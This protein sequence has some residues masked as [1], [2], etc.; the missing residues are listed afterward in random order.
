MKKKMTLRD[1]AAEAN[2]SLTAASLYLNGKARQYRISEEA[3]ARLKEVIERE[4][5]QPNL[6]ARAMAAKRTDLV[7]CMLCNKLDESFWAQI[8]SGIDEVLSARGIHLLMT[9]SAGGLDEELKS[10]EYLRAKGVD[11]IIWGPVF[12]EGRLMNDAFASQ[13]NRELPVVALAENVPGITSVFNDG[14]TGGADAARHLLEHGHRELMI[15]GFSSRHL[16]RVEAFRATAEEGGARVRQFGTAGELLDALPA[17]TAAYCVTDYAALALYQEAARR[18]I[19]IPEALSV[20]GFDNMPFCE[21]LSPP[22][23][24]VNQQKGELGRRAAEVM[25]RQLDQRF[26]PESFRLNTELVIR[27]SV[28]LR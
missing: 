11:G 5:Y 1:I 6:N 21:L 14:A 12:G 27:Q 18:G 23:S 26:A 22:L 10:F 24:S 8:I 17:G 15:L 4:H 20:I 3:C 19:A 2:V 7:G 13:L 16:D 9:V 28:T 25:L